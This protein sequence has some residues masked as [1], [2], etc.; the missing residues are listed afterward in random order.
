MRYAGQVSME[1]FSEAIDLLAV[2]LPGASNKEQFLHTCKLMD[3]NNDGQV[4]LNEFLEAFRIVD[5]QR[6]FINNSTETPQK[7]SIYF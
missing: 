3:L 4:D 2:H 5:Q 1:E 6:S 7:K